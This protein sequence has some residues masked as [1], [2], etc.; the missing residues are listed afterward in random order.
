MIGTL[1]GYAERGMILG[2][3][4]LIKDTQMTKFYKRIVYCLICLG[5][6]TSF[7]PSK[8][9]S[10]AFDFYKQPVP[11]FHEIGGVFMK[12]NDFETA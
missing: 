5:L 4:A 12:E 3:S 8:V 7:Q 6:K 1:R 9:S 10:K 11:H 2:C